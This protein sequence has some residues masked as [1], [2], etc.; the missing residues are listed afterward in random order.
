MTHQVIPGPPATHRLPPAQLLPPPYLA[1]MLPPPHTITAASVATHLRT[2]LLSAPPLP[3]HRLRTG[4]SM[5]SHYHRHHHRLHRHGYRHHPPPSPLMVFCSCSLWQP[6]FFYTRV[7]THSLPTDHNQP[8]PRSPHPP[9][10]PPPPPH[11]GLNHPTCSNAYPVVEMM[12]TH[13]HNHGVYMEC[14]M[15][16][17]L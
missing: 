14:L 3:P 8:H 17:A 1:E 11:Y 10:L 6:F 12:N 16:N 4:P 5:Q 2:S 7:P 13:T 15:E 9:P